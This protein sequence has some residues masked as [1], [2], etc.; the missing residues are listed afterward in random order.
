MLIDELS[1]TKPAFTSSTTRIFRVVPSVRT[2]HRDCERAQIERY[3]ADGRQLDRHA[4]RTTL[5]THL[6]RAG[7][8]PQQ[9]MKMLGH[10]DVRITMKHYTD[11]R[12]SDTAKALDTLPDIHPTTPEAQSQVMR[13][14]GTEDAKADVLQ[15]SQIRAQRNQQRSCDPSELATART[16]NGVSNDQ[17]GNLK[18]S[19]NVPTRKNREKVAVG[20][21]L[22]PSDLMPSDDAANM[23]ETRAVGAV[24]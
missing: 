17:R 20:R 12:L 7:V 1:K 14:T 9:A 10:T 23:L 8:L 18:I 5:G 24:G 11:L 6:A 16:G 3:D 4:L 13:A 21:R 15:N 19:S 2:F 22:A